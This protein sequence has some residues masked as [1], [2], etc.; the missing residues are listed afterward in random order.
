MD[1]KIRTEI[2]DDFRN[3]LKRQQY[4]GI[5]LKIINRSNEI[6]KGYDFIRIDNQPNGESD[7]VDN[8][9]SKYDV[10]LLL[11]KKQGALIGEKKNDICLWISSMMQECSEYCNSINMRDL[12]LVKDT[13][14]YQIMKKRLCTVKHDENVILFSPFP[15]VN[16]FRGSIT[17]QMTTDFLQAVFERLKDEKIYDCGKVYF[18][19]PSME[20]GILVL[21]DEKR[22]REYI[23]SPEITKYISFESL[24]V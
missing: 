5:V 4:E 6:F 8:F 20:K 11:D 13:K 14:L 19:Y 10:K 3:I 9:G 16:D 1:I 17:M 7:F 23:Y 22:T 21:R 12:S 18:L 2:S 15:I 24:P